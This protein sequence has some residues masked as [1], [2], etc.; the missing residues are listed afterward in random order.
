MT[1][2]N[3]VKV[4]FVVV[5]I[6]S[7]AIV[8]IW[9][10]WRSELKAEGSYA[11]IIPLD[12]KPASCPNPINV[13]S[14]GNLP[15]A[16]LG[17]WDYDVSQIDPA[18]VRLLDVAPERSNLEDVATPFDPDLSIQTAYDCNDWGADGFTDLTLKFDT[19]KI[20]DKLGEVNDGDVYLLKLT[21]EFRDGTKMESSDVVLILK[22]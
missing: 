14:K 2:M 11:L 8:G 10:D 12:I 9:P 18:S 16:I 13:K 4:S 6:M 3:W 17:T 21:G 7:L 1:K 19:Q 20:V 15:V 5:I 22:K